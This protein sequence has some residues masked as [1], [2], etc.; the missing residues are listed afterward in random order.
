M[1]PA[2]SIIS[3]FGVPAAEGQDAKSGAD[4]VSSIVHVHK[5]TPYRWTWPTSQGGTGGNIPIKYHA[6]LLSAAERLGLPLR[7]EHFLPDQKPD[8]TSCSEVG[9]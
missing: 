2:I 7:R 8:F 4:M 9:E 1:E 5:S 3:L 6:P